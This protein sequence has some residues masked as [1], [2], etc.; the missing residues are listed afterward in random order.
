MGLWDQI[1]ATP[2]RVVIQTVAHTKGDVHAKSTHNKAL[3]ESGG[4]HKHSKVEPG[5]K[6]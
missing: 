1:F 2:K 5:K 3:P 4:G 6:K